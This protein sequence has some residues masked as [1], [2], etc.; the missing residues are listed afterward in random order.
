MRKHLKEITGVLDIV[1]AAICLAAAF[2]YHLSG[3]TSSAIFLILVAIF[4]DRK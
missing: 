4:F 1:I 3:D 2:Y